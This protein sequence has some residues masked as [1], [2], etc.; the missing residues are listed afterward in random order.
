MKRYFA[1]AFCLF[2]FSPLAQGQDTRKRLYFPQLVVGDGWKV[3]FNYINI[4]EE[5][6]VLGVQSYLYEEKLN[7]STNPNIWNVQDVIPLSR[8]IN[9]DENLVIAPLIMVGSSPGWGSTMPRRDYRETSL[10][11]TGD[12][13]NQLIGWTELTYDNA[14]DENVL[15]SVTLQR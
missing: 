11:R 7:P 14:Q 12:S 8:F 10:E 3:V 6:H 2:A 1:V 5:T 4:A 13:N 15:A 9:S